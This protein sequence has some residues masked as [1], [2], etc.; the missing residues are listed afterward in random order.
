MIAL[1]SL[2]F[3]GIPMVATL[4]F[5]AAIA[6]VVAVTAAATLLPAMFGGARTAHQLA[7]GAAGQDPPRRQ[8]AAGW[9]RRADWVADRPWTAT[10]ASLAT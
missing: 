2:A 5:T 6:V 7:A 1:C 8:E 10:V 4:G 3:A 9:L